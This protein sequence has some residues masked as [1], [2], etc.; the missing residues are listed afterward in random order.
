MSKCLQVMCLITVL[1]LMSVA[2]KAALLLNLPFD[3]GTNP[4]MV[5]YGTLGGAATDATGTSLARKT[6]WR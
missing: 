1:G 2:A 3:D 4:N 6:G 5:N